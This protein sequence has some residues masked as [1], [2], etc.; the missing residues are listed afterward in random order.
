M[1]MANVGGKVS[2]RLTHAT[3]A[4]QT[5]QSSLAIGCNISCVIVRVLP[6]NY[7][8]LPKPPAS[9]RVVIFPGGLRPEY[10]AFGSYGS[11]RKRRKPRRNTCAGCSSLVAMARS[12][13]TC[14][15]DHWREQEFHRVSV[16][17]AADCWVVAGQNCPGKGLK[18]VSEYKSD[19]K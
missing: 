8:L 7:C 11:Q 9:A 18:C 19:D 1:A 6:L 16:I 12:D 13:P 2:K 3:A 5:S 17:R 14:V 15:S 4:T 10:A